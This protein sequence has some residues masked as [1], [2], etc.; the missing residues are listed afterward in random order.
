MNLL[1]IFTGMLS[2]GL[3]LWQDFKDREIHILWLALFCLSGILHFYLG[4]GTG[5]LMNL[6]ISYSLVSLM[7]FILVFLTKMLTGQRVMDRQLGWGDIFMLYG[8]ASWWETFEFLVFYTLSL[9]MLASLFL[10]AQKTNRIP[11]NY[12][13]P[14][15]G[16][17][18]L[19]FMLYFPLT[20][21]FS[22]TTLLP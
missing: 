13:I 5:A 3:I 2:A 15:A 8:L 21:F 9:W 14:L 19:T 11:K 16:A 10:I 12:P 18:A 1:F 22:L 17:W 7:L 6:G 20:Q 4:K